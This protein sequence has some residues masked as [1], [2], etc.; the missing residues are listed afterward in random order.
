MLSIRFLSSFCLLL[1]SNSWVRAL[2][3]GIPIR[4]LRREW[5]KQIINSRAKLFFSRPT[6][7][8][9][10]VIEDQRRRSELLRLLA[11]T[12]LYV[13][14]YVWILHVPI[15][16]SYKHDNEPKLQS[17]S[18][19]GSS[20]TINHAWLLCAHRFHVV[21]QIRLGWEN[22]SIVVINNKIV[23]FVTRGSRSALSKCVAKQHASNKALIHNNNIRL[24]SEIISFSPSVEVSSGSFIRPF[25]TMN[26]R[27]HY[28]FRAR[29]IRCTT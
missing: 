9:W 28:L 26:R 23:F 4:V 22:I 2:R 24:M 12:N 16:C 3:W 1:H 27:F 7:S 11:N 25:N 21:V 8:A 17:E 15:V 10:S 14:D 19:P 13:F 29:K 18:V 6:F 20:R 5:K